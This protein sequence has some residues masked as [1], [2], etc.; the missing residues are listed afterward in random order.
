MTLLEFQRRMASDVMRP[1]TPDEQMDPLAD[2]GS[3]MDAAA[4]AYVKPS[5]TLTPFERLEIYNRQY[6]FRLLDA[7]SEDYPA[8]QALM[9]AEDFDRMAR[10]YLHQNRSTSF[11]LRNLGARLPAWMKAQNQGTTLAQQVA[12]LEWAYVESFDASQFEAMRLEQISAIEDVHPMALQP[13]IHLLAFDAAVDDLVLALRRAERPCSHDVRDA[14]ARAASDAGPIWV[15][16]HRHDFVVHY[17]RLDEGEF[18]LLAALRD[19]KTLDQALDAVCQV[20]AIDVQKLVA[21]VGR[22]LERSAT[23]GW[24][25][26]AP[27]QAMERAN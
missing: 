14:L 2:D 24:I 8:L 4:S 16:V 7:L 23:L 6:W 13:H 9:G 11:T 20:Q 3:G 10:A 5:S 17:R 19:G 27:D 1:L 22:W 18:V 25:C 12:Q 26:P 15:A 21:D